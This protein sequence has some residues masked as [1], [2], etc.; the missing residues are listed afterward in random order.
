MA[1]TP[2]TSP[3]SLQAWCTHMMES[4]TQVQIDWLVAGSSVNT[5]PITAVGSDYVAVQV[6]PTTTR[7][8]PFTSLAWI[9]PV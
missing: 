2:A 3:I 9:T 7:V 5:G 6:T 4:G 8:V 1:A